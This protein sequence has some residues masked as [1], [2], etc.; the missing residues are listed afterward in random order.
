MIILIILFNL[1]GPIYGNYSISPLNKFKGTGIIL[2][3]STLLYKKDANFTTYLIKGYLGLYYN[4][5][6]HITFA[7]D[8]R[9]RFYY[10]QGDTSY[11]SFYLDN[12]LVGTKFG[13]PLTQNSDMALG[14]N[15]SVPINSLIDKDSTDLE[16]YPLTS[17]LSPGLSLYHFFKKNHFGIS[18]SIGY[19]GPVYGKRTFSLKLASTLF[20]EMGNNRVFVA[21]GIVL[22]PSLP[23]ETSSS[24]LTITGGISFISQFSAAFTIAFTIRPLINTN[25]PPLVF[26]LGD[27]YKYGLGITIESWFPEKRLKRI[28]RPRNEPKPQFVLIKRFCNVTFKIL[29][30]ETQ[31]RID[32][33]NVKILKD[34]HLI[35]KLY[36]IGNTRINSIKFGNYTFTF[37]KPGYNPTTLQTKLNSDTIITLFMTKKQLKDT[38]TLILHIKDNQ[39]TPLRNVEVNIIGLNLSQ[40]SDSVGRV[41]FKLRNGRY[42]MKI[43]KL[44]YKP[45]SR[46]FIIKKE[47]TLNE[48][49]MLNKK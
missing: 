5:D 17:S 39:G 26:L 13:F 14:L 1:F 37:Q 2:P 21:P 16:G 24:T 4:Y 44:G 33:V 10:T 28:Y 20:Y 22:Y 49:I 38:G 46:Y 34:N 31:K 35:K 27:A 41:E 43:H 6:Q 12:I 42:L 15:L 45:I 47:Q 29:D 48:T 9:G 7:T 8:I 3:H 19:T 36:L 11:N 23:E 25:E 32:S 18:S 30:S 40:K